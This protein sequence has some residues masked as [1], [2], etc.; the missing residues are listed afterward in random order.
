MGEKQITFFDYMM[1]YPHKLPDRLRLAAEFR[2]LS[3]FAPE[4]KKIDSLSDLMIAAQMIDD[5]MIAETASGPLWC[6][7][8]I[9]SG[10]SIT[11]ELQ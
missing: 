8:C 3:R 5:P 2:R 9:F 11:D 6:E 7:Y 10:R 1:R 4:I